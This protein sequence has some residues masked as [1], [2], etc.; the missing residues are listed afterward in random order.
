MKVTSILAT[1]M[2][3]GLVAGAPPNERPTDVQ[4]NPLPEPTAA[5]VALPPAHGDN[6][7]DKRDK[8]PAPPKEEVKHPKAVKDS[9]KRDQR[10]A[11]PGSPSSQGC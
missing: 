7:N 4:G 1:L 3:A 10:Q 9:G 8:V 2:A 5:E 11:G 6:D